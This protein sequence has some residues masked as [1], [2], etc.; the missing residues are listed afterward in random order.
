MEC[1]DETVRIRYDW[2]STPPSAAVVETVATALDCDPM[3]MDPL[4]EYIDPDALDDLVGASDSN[5]TGRET[6]IS[7]R[8]DGHRVTVSGSGEVAVRTVTGS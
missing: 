7:F 8:F 6:S 2:S 5:P 1:D 3:E 4:Y